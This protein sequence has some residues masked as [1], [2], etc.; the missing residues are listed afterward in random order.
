MNSDILAE[1]LGRLEAKPDT[2]KMRVLVKD[3]ANALAKK[4]ITPETAKNLIE[5]VLDHK[6]NS[7]ISYDK[8]R[9]PVCK[10][11]W[12]DDTVHCPECGNN[13][14]AT[15]ID[16]K[17]YDAVRAERF[18]RLTKHEKVPRDFAFMSI[19]TDIVHY[20]RREGI[21]LTEVLAQ[22]ETEI[23]KQEAKP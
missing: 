22:V 10:I 18:G 13:V 12:P 23:S 9:C 19:L 21:A 2:E 11:E 8:A 17:T 20:C 5:K 16:G 15:S 7:E 1:I 4:F 14:Q 3:I 6:T